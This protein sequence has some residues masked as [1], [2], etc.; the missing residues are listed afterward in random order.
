MWDLKILYPLLDKNNFIGFSFQMWDLKLLKYLKQ[1]GYGISFSFQMWDLK[2]LEAIIK[3][4][5]SLVLAFKCG[6]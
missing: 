3:E 4:K 6:I 2:Q 5:E 1:N